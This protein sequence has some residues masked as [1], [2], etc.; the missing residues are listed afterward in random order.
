MGQYH[1]NIKL[2]S[3]AMVSSGTKHRGKVTNMSGGGNMEKDC[4]DSCQ[5]LEDIVST[6][7]DEVKTEQHLELKYLI[8]MF[9]LLKAPDAKD[10]E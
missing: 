8:K 10:A 4:S 3:I 7:K 2:A 5:M 9:S 1:G 6:F